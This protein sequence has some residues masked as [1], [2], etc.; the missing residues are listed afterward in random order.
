[1]YTVGVRVERRQWES[2][3]GKTYVSILLRHSYREDGHVRKRTI[4]NLTHCPPEDVRA[5]ELALDYKNNLAALGSVKD[6]QIAGSGKYCHLL[7]GNYCH[8]WGCDF[9]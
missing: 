9:R 3:N 8:S 5:I 1:M 2:T 7:S 4:A 6:I